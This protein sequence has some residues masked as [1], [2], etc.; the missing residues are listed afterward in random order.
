MRDPKPLGPGKAMKE[1]A[2]DHLTMFPSCLFMIYEHL[3]EGKWLQGYT[4]GGHK[5]KNPRMDPDALQQTTAWP[6]AVHPESTES[7]G[8]MQVGIA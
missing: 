5:K 8:S 2:N 4:S 1:Q 6:M 3:C 7:T